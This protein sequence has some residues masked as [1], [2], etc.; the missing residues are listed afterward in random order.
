M[1]ARNEAYEALYLPE[2]ERRLANSIRV[3]TV[4]ELDPAKAR[5]RIKSGK[6]TTGWLPWTVG[7]AGPDRQWSAPEVGEQ[8][9]IAAPS[10]D[11]TQAIVLGSLYQKKHPAPGDSADNTITEWG[12]GAKLSYDRASHTYTL[13]VP[14]GGTINLNSGG[15]QFSI[16]DSSVTMK[17]QRF[18]VDAAETHFTGKVTSDGDMIAMHVSQAHHVHR[19]T[20]SGPGT[21]GLPLADA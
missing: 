14:A 21:S 19:D 6:L 7:R 20:M 3:G 15:T 13:T 11:L 1:T 18:L 9:I 16:T 2:L 5:V 4:A 10:G 8:V 12:D 17:T